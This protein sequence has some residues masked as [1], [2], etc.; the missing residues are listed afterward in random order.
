MGGVAARV[1]V[2]SG[3]AARRVPEAT[4]ARLTDYLQV[5][6]DMR[7]SGNRTVS[8]DGLADGAHVTS[9]QVRMDLSYLG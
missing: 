1:S 3:S 2:A 6:V 5:L 8:S 4:V 7:E 9:A